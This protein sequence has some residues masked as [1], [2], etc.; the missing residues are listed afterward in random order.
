MGCIARCSRTYQGCGAWEPKTLITPKRPFTSSLPMPLC[1]IL[2]AI[3]RDWVRFTATYRDA[4]RRSPPG[5]VFDFLDWPPIT[6]QHS[7]HA[8]VTAYLMPRQGGSV[9]PEPQADGSGRLNTAPASARD[10]AGSGQRTLKTNSA[11]GRLEPFPQPPR[12]KRGRNGAILRPPGL[13]CFS[14]AL[15]SALE[16]FTISLPFLYRNRFCDGKVCCPCPFILARLTGTNRDS[17]R[18]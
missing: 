13:W 3:S 15:R 2:G 7:L 6:Y 1:F 16:R 5:K 9:Q 8:C 11:S 4:A 18:Q 10:S 17:A 12:Q 14:A